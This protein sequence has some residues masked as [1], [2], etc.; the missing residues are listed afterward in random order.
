MVETKRTARRVL[1]V[2][3]EMMI[4]MLVEDMLLDLGCEVVGPASHLDDAIALA[5]SEDIDFA[6][7]DINLGGR[8]SFPVADVLKERGIAFVFASG[9]GTDGLVGSHTD[10]RTL[11]KPFDLPDLE[12][13]LHALCPEPRGA[14]GNRK[15]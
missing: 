2:E 11:A 9:Y 8:A 6:V 4:A 3:D 14:A 7:L 1:V 13:A 10:A 12:G 15:G 5:R